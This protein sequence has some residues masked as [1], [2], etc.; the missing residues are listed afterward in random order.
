[1]GPQRSPSD[2]RPARVSA[3][4]S[5]AE[6]SRHRIRSAGAKVEVSAGHAGIE[7]RLLRRHVDAHALTFELAA[8]RVSRLAMIAVVAAELFR[9]NLG[10]TGRSRSAAMSGAAAVTL[11][12]MMPATSKHRV[13]EEQGRS[14]VGKPSA[15]RSNLSVSLSLSAPK[16]TELESDRRS[17][18]VRIR[19]GFATSCSSRCNDTS[20]GRERTSHKSSLRN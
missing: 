4:G 8:A 18:A 7:T 11:V 3:S 12:R 17:F 9:R 13:D 16:S 1:M 19:A 2:R 6:S 15:H 5:F 14:Q 20:C 10:K